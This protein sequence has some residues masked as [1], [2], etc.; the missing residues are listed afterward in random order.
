MNSPDG[1]GMTIKIRYSNAKTYG[2]YN[3]EG[4]YIPMNEYDKTI[5]EPGLIKQTHCGENRYLAQKSTLEFYM[6]AHC[7]LEIRPR[8]VIQAM[9]RM[10]WD[11]DGFFSDGGTT[12]FADRMAGAL[13]IPASD[14][15]VIDV[16]EGSVIVNYDISVPED[17]ST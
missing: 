13:G 15:K 4:N 1:G 10:K 9:V 17:E 14:L 6:P 7:I 2:M 11:L 3:G 8:N 5:K 16:Y 12:T